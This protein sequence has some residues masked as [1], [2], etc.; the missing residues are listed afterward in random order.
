MPETALLPLAAPTAFAPLLASALDRADLFEADSGPEDSYDTAPLAWGVSKITGVSGALSAALDLADRPGRARVMQTMPLPAGVLMLIQIAAGSSE[1]LRHLVVVTGREPAFIRAAALVYIERILWVPDGDHYRALGVNRDSR[2]REIAKH[3]LWFAKWVS[4]EWGWSE[5]QEAF[6]RKVLPA[7][8]VLKSR[9]LRREYD[10]AT[11]V[12]P[13]TRIV[14]EAAVRL[15]PPEQRVRW[16]DQPEFRGGR[17]QTGR[18]ETAPW[19]LAALG[20]S[21]IVVAA[22]SMLNWIIFQL[23]SAAATST[24][25]DAYETS[26]EDLDGRELLAETRQAASSLNRLA[27]HPKDTSRLVLPSDQ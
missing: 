6:A 8:N 27:A 9:E 21:I 26:A 4:Q 25:S 13:K 15:A 2:P 1:A 19:Q 18:P 23:P 17:R 7:W 3:L 12:A 10:R 11:L 16:A 24:T 14:P 5:L 22:V 20:A